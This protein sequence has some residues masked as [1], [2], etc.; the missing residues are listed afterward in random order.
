MYV[1]T[2]SSANVGY[3]FGVLGYSEHAAASHMLLLQ[4]MWS[5]TKCYHS[6]LA[7]THTLLKI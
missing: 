3:L 6:T 7:D 5:W 4:Q 1:D 2:A